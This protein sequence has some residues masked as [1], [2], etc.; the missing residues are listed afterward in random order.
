MGVLTDYLA[1]H[2]SINTT[3]LLAFR[4][5][6]DANLLD[7]FDRGDVTLSSDHIRVLT[8][9][10][11]ADASTVLGTD[12]GPR[13]VTSVRSPRGRVPEGSQLL[14]VR[15]SSVEEGDLVS[16]VPPPGVPGTHWVLVTGV[17]TFRQRGHEYVELLSGSTRLVSVKQDHIIRI[18]RLG[19]Q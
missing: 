13:T 18:A 12:S 9:E 15:A 8:R 3:Q 7:L 17:D 10:L 19:G 6:V 2:P 4:S 14:T 1:T 5:G 11:G 16:Y